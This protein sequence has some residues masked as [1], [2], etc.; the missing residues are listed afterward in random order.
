MTNTDDCERC[1]CKVKKYNPKCPYGTDRER[2]LMVEWQKREDE[3][4]QDKTLE[5]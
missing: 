5:Y 4:I 2:G 3:K 1:L